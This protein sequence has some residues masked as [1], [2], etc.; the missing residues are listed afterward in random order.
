VRDD[1]SDGLIRL[2]D[3]IRSISTPHRLTREIAEKAPILA[4]E[5]REKELIA[6]S[7]D[8]VRHLDT[9]QL[10]GGPTTPILNA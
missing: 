7:Y 4:K 8:K 3:V 6:K 10:M 5:R 2:C 1:L 9:I